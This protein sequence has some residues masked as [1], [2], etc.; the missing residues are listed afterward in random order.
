MNIAFFLDVNCNHGYSWVESIAKKNNVIIF[1]TEAYSTKGLY[2]N[3]NIKIF[4]LLLNRFPLNNPF[5][6][7]SSVKKIKNILE[8][9]NI[10][11][12]H[13]MYAI[14]FA[15][16]AYSCHHGKLIITTRGSDILVEYNNVYLNPDSL[17]QKINYNSLRKLFEKSLQKADATTSTSYSQANIVSQIIKDR[18]KLNVIR[19]G[20]NS[21]NFAF[22][23]RQTKKNKNEFIIFSPRTMRPLYNQDLIVKGFHLFTEKNPA[24]NTRLKLIDFLSF[25]DYL[26]SVKKIIADLKLNDKVDILPSQTKKDL[27]Q[28]YFDA[29]VV[30]MLPESDGTPVSG[31]ETMF[32]KTA[33]LVG[34]AHYDNDLFNENTVW[35]LKNKSAE[36]IGNKLLE[37][38][39]CDKFLLN[40][41]INNAYEIALQKANLSQSLLKIES[42]YSE[43]METNT[44]EAEFKFCKKCGLTT[45]DNSDLYVNDLELCFNCE[46]LK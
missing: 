43:L 33:L 41:K 10:E 31:I 44:I 19:T 22:V 34:N 39:N 37:I 32:A 28:N 16:W 5:K 45:I 17:L 38:Y 36:E 8:D 7:K 24:I 21:N 6:L 42:I 4:P 35:K 25:P 11:I 2:D 12:L 3:S 46:H 26:N 20:V 18:R 13:A 1:T 23:N 9:N 29:D 14:P 15:F 30:I 40:E 27:I